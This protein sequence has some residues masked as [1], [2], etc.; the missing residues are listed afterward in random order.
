M[1]IE[2]VLSRESIPFLK[3]CV[4]CLP[5][6]CRDYTALGDV[7]SGDINAGRELA[8]R[9]SSLHLLPMYLRREASWVLSAPIVQCM[10]KISGSLTLCP[11]Q[12]QLLISQKDWTRGCLLTGLVVEAVLFLKMHG[13]F[14]CSIL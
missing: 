3:H 4:K 7:V 5:T 14:R 11:L 13:W 6:D 1:L 10:F 8:E 9:L 12:A 2:Q